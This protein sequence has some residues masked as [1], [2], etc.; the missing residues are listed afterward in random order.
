MF[1]WQKF[2][3]ISQ[4]VS[5]TLMQALT[6]PFNAGKKKGR[7]SDGEASPP[8]PGQGSLVIAGGGKVCDEII[9]QV[10]HLAGGRDRQVII[11]PTGGQRSHQTSEIFRRF[12]RRFGVE[13]AECLPLFTREQAGNN[14]QVEKI[15]QAKVICLTPGA[16]PLLLE[17]IRDTPAEEA[18]RE[19]YRLGGVVVGVGLGGVLL[20]KLAGDVPGLGLLPSCILDQRMTEKNS[21]GTLMQQAA[22]AL[23]AGLP[24]IAVEEETALVL[25]HDEFRVIGRRSALVFDNHLGEA[26]PQEPPNSAAVMTDTLVHLLPPGYGFDLT[27][28]RPLPPQNTAKEAVL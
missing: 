13:Q 2:S 3:D 16:L 19:S 18:L 22:N 6:A 26:S 17:V 10:I 7:P 23:R 1:R 14:F 11:L 8:G 27:S 20:G 25:H 9:L 21:L 28:R 15:R 24:A 4:E 12:F 5:S